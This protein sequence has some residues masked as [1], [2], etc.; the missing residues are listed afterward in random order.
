MEN[1][2]GHKEHFFSLLP[3]KARGIFSGGPR[4]TIVRRK[5]R[6]KQQLFV[7][8][9][10]RVEI[11]ENLTGNYRRVSRKSSWKNCDFRA[12]KNFGYSR[13]GL[14]GSVKSVQNDLI[15]QSWQVS[16]RN[17]VYGVISC[18]IGFGSFAQHLSDI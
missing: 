5:S 12:K 3:A 6:A 14:K 8:L 1:C 2:L 9:F 11:T 10:P 18:V 17:A 16:L 7:Q 15:D 13:L 4:C